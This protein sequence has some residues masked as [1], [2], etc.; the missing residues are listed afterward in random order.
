MAFCSESSAPAFWARA[1]P[2]QGEDGEGLGAGAG[3]W[4][5]VD[6]LESGC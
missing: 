4:V 3:T 1:M 5:S 2:L 6:W